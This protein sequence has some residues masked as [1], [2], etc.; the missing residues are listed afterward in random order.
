MVWIQPSRVFHTWKGIE[1]PIQAVVV[2]L[3]KVSVED[4][5]MLSMKSEE[6]W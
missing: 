1:R 6:Q 4:G 3:A 2:A 5:V